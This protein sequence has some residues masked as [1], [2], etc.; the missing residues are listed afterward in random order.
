MVPGDR[1]KVMLVSHAYSE[2]E[3]RKTALSLANLCDLKVVCPRKTD[4]LVFR[5]HVFVHDALSRATFVPLRTVKLVGAQF[6]FVSIAF[7]L[8]RYSPDVLYIEYDPWSVVFWQCQ[9]LRVL[10]WRR[11]VVVCGVKKNTYRRYEGSLGR[12]KYSMARLGV[13]QVRHFV[14]ASIR[15][16]KLFMD[17]FCVPARRISVD[18]HL[19][20]DT[21]LFSPPAGKATATD[22]PI[23]IGMCG[24]LDVHKGILDAV[25]AVDT[26]RMRSAREI[27]LTLVGNGRL[28][29]ELQAMQKQRP[30][31]KLEGLVPTEDVARLMKTFDIYLMPS[32][33]LPDHE[34]HDAHALLQAL[35]TGIASIGSQS[36][37]IPEI[38]GGGIGLLVDPGVKEQLTVAI[39]H[40]INDT[41]LRS[42]LG[43]AGRRKAET[44]F[45]NTG[46]ARRRVRILEEV[47]VGSR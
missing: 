18:T 14:S 26:C 2:H 6:L 31:L 27:Q 45:S 41:D 13:R 17:V 30:W 4:V 37:I 12:I 40:L 9:L 11:S 19:G 39:E 38:L 47:L 24:R 15:T 36:G 3:L 42:R 43:A 46:I 29:D 5:N 28:Y 25:E 20:V 8:R 10:W 22:N 7:R 35:S 23:I 1:L 34:E 44:R 33:V 21:E 16:K 32:H